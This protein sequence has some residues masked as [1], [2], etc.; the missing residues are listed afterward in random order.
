MEGLTRRRSSKLEQI[1][2]RTNNPLRYF[3]P[4]GEKATVTTNCTTND[5]IQTTCNVKIQASIAIY[6]AEGSN[7]TQEQLQAAASTIQSSIQD[8]WNGTFVQDGVTY[9]VTTQVSVEVA[10]SQGAA[11]E[12]GAQNV[13]AMTNGPMTI[14]G[15]IFGGQVYTK[16]LAGLLTPG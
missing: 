7:L 6:A 14:N 5:Q 16:S 3:D 11:M 10:A 13:I 4:T 15:R 12:T 8:A 2:L 1:C 9:N